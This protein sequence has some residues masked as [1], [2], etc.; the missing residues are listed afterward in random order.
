MFVN[1]LK[2]FPRIDVS[3]G[4]GMIWEDIIAYGT[5]TQGANHS[6][7]C[8]VYAVLEAPKGYCPRGLASVLGYEDS[9]DIDPGAM[10]AAALQIRCCAL[11]S[12]QPQGQECCDPDEG[13]RLGR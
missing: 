6:R 4:S 5:S 11:S 8:L 9:L 2:M 13:L 1:P 12:Q 3:G 10:H 7:H